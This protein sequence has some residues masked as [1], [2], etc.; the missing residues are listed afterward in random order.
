MGTSKFMRR[1]AS[2][3]L[4]AALVTTFVPAAI[5]AH[6]ADVTVYS[7]DGYDVTYS[8]EQS[9]TGAQSICVTLTNTGDEPILNWALKYDLE[10]TPTYMWNASVY[11]NEDSEYIVKNLG[12]NYEVAPDHSVSFGYILAT[13][14][15][16]VAPTA[17]ELCS[18]R[19][20]VTEDYDV[21][22]NY[23]DEWNTGMRGEVTITNNTDAPLEAWTLAFDTNFTITDLWDARLIGT[24]DN[25]Y[26]VASTLWTNAIP[27]GGSVTFGFVGNV[28]D[29]GDDYTATVDNYKLT[30][31]VIDPEDKPQPTEDLVLSA[32]EKEIHKSA[33]TKTVYFYAQTELDVTSVTLYDASTDSVVASML[34]DGKFSVSGDDMQG[35][36]IYSCKLDL[37]ISAKKDYS[38]VAKGTDADGDYI[39]NDIAVVVYED[40]SDD[41]KAC[42]QE[43]KNAI[44]GLI[45]SD[46]FHALPIEEKV[47]QTQALLESLSE[48][49]TENKPFSLIKEGSIRYNEA[50]KV[51]T[52]KYPSG[53]ISVVKL[54]EV[55]AGSTLGGSSVVS[56]TDL[57]LTAPIADGVPAGSVDAKVFNAVSPQISVPESLFDGW[58]DLGAS[59]SYDDTVTVDELKSELTGK[60]ITYIVMHG[61]YADFDE[62]GTTTIMLTNEI[63]SEDNIDAHSHDWEEDRISAIMT[64]DSED[65]Y[66]VVL[67]KLF[68]DYYS[69][70]KLDDSVVALCTCESFGAGA[71]YFYGLGDAF[72]NS[73]ASAVLGFHNSVYADYA[74]PFAV[75]LFE[76]MLSGDTVGTAYSNCIS[77]YGSDD[78]DGGTPV[79]YGDGDAL[80]DTGNL[81][82]GDFEKTLWPLTTLN[83][84]IPGWKKGGDA[85]VITQ[86]GSIDTISNNRMAILTTGVGSGENVYI[87]GGTEGSYLSQTFKIPEGAETLSFYYDFVSEEPMEYVGSQY[88]DRF[89]ATIY[90]VNDVEVL[91]AAYESVNTSQWTPVSGIDFDGGDHTCYETG[92]KKVN[93]D[94][95]QCVGKYISLRFSVTDVGD[96]I[97][98][99]AVLID[100]VSFS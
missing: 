56:E 74:I 60:E 67:P 72:I 45:N 46:S 36:G 61:L 53:I 12:W 98:D 38:F 73:G 4:S 50:S 25:R 24:E 5:F 89:Y 21:S 83:L 84:F 95:S 78:G 70:G 30:S 68:S 63:C 40:F 28:A 27:A 29:K 65:P 97:Y 15:E 22:V 82:N 71:D 62:I 33:G 69:G 77:T 55:G 8:V 23:T 81:I 49:G 44:S 7:Y 85:R 14:E 92:W 1:A 54:D 26:T 39:S 10:G 57:V 37:D 96:S 19:V 51:F 90:D 66:Y 99:T 86:L 3:I 91:S 11:S 35:D 100:N 75:D 87:S 93:I 80:I 9:W 59:V 2:G 20:D 94:V 32:S 76:D 31:V 52:F 43:V 16:A 34:D 79:L 48:N 13:E 18:Q 6:A 47:A 42:I 58:E 88:D 17:F 64:E 41:Q